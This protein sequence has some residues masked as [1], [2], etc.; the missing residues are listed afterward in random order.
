MLIKLKSIYKVKTDEFSGVLKNKARLVA[1]GFR[2]EEGINFEESFAPVSRIEAINIFVANAANKNM[3]IFQMDV[4]TAFLNGKLKEEVYVSQPEGFVYQD[5]PS[6]VYKLKKA[7][8]GLKQAPRTWYN[9]VS[10]FLISQHISKGAVDPTLFTRKAG[11]DLLLGIDMIK[12]YKEA[13]VATN[14]SDD[15]RVGMKSSKSVPVTTDSNRNSGIPRAV[16]IHIWYD[17]Q[18]VDS[19][20]FDC[21]VNDKYKTGERYHAVLPPYIGNFMPLKPNLVLADEEEYAFSESI[22]SVPAVA[23]SKV[24]TSESKPKSVSEP[25]IEDWISDSEDENETEFK[26]KLRKPSFAKVEF[27]K[28]NEHVKIHRESVEKVENN[29]QAKHPRKNSQSPR[30]NKR[31]WNN[32]MTQKLGSNFEFKNKACYVCGSF[33]HLIKDCDFY[34]KK[35]VEKPV[36]NHASRV[37][38]QN[39]QRST[40][41]HPKGKFVPK[42]VLIKSGHKTLNTASL[43][44]SKAAVS[45]NTTRPINTAYL[46]PTVNSARTA[47]NV[48]NKAYSHVR[49]PFNKFTTNKNSNLNEKVN[50]IR[51]N[52]TNVG[53]K[54]V[55]SD[56]KGNEAN[57]VK[58]SAC[59]VWRPKQKV[60]NHVS[61]QRHMTG[62]KSYLSYYEE[63]DGGFIAFGGDP[64]GGKIASKGKI[65]TVR[66]PVKYAEMYKS[67]NPRG[68]QRNWNNQKSQQ[69]GSDFVMYNKACFV[70]GSFDHVQANCNYHQRE[71]VVSGS[72]Y[73]RV[74]YNYSAK[75]AH[76]NAHRNMVPRAVLMKT[77]LRTLNTARPVNTAHPKTTIYSAR[78]MSHFSKSAQSTVKRPYQMRTTLTNKNFSK[79]F[80]I[81]MGK[82]YTARLNTTVVNAVRANQVNTVKVSAWNMSYLSD[83]KEFNGGYVI[84]GGGAKGERIIVVAGTNSNDFVDGS[85][86]DSSTKNTINNEPQPSSDAGKKDDDGGIDNQEGP[87]NSSQEVNIVGPSINTASTNINTGSLNINIVSL[88]VT[89]APLEATHADFFGDETKLDMSNITNPY[90][91]PTTPS[92][93]IHKDHLL[94]HV[95]GDVQSGVQTRRM[96]KTTNEQ[97]FIIVVYERKTHEDLHTY[98]FA[99]FL[100]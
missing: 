50:T 98:Q 3:A 73:T 37:N 68:N 81:A 93:R 64:K 34:E 42:A 60:L 16:D 19:Q 44:S 28:S 63:I 69:L 14:M 57:A 78:P 80:N 40:Y 95:I 84:F 32:L 49:R 45:V 74:N 55:V 9:T 41:P 51:R 83:F 88:L 86:F 15:V 67:Q 29:K 53:S 76:P 4:K 5:N 11:N 61:E 99:C 59:W 33:N 75:K 21:Q 47:S 26:S 48:F 90:L 8:Y 62:N 12:R 36:W 54:A 66:K 52:V 22:T 31:N 92:T 96:S 100:S 13:A 6:H 1:Q 27:V 65:S 70:C 25:L 2:K 23:T 17:S 10:S 30:G 7:L 20:V 87:E 46:R 43:N 72:N 85:L 71:R 18:V 82:F 56:N 97:G 94:Y 35:M 24:K 39:S 58:A 79:K 77:G 91:V 89:T 38:H